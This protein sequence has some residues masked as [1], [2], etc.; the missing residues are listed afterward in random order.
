[1]LKRINIKKTVIFSIILL[2]TLLFAL[3]Y[4]VF[5]YEEKSP[6]YQEILKIHKNKTTI[7]MNFEQCIKLLGKTDSKKEDEQWEF[8]G[9][10]ILLLNK[11]EYYVL[12]LVRDSDGRVVS[13]Y[14]QQ[15]P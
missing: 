15:I 14:I 7:G 10:S 5:L 2:I 3:F 11:R 13:S 8:D 9:G 12:R 6:R 1:M 4:R